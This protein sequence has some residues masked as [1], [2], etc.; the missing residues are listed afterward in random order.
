MLAYPQQM[1]DDDD[2]TG[3]KKKVHDGVHGSFFKGLGWQ[4]AL[5]WCFKIYAVASV[6]D[7]P[8]LDGCKVCHV[9]V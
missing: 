3:K 8:L 6:V 2:C 5:V 9:Q 4:L 1:S 7:C